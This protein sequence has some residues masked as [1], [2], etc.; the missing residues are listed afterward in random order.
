[1][2]KIRQG[3]AGERITACPVHLLD[4]LVNN[5]L[6]PG[7]SIRSMGHFPNAAGHYI[8]RPCG[9]AEYIFIYCTNGRGWYVLF[10]EKHEVRAG[11]YFILP[12]GV[13][14]SYGASDGEPW[15]IYWAHFI[16][17]KA[18]SVYESM[19]GTHTLKIEEKTRIA[20][21][22]RMFDELLNVMERRTD[23][24]S[25]LYV[26][27]GFY[28]IMSTLMFVDAFR[29]ARY[30]SAPPQNIRFLNRITHFMMENI[31]RNITVGDMAEYMGY[32]ESHFHRKF[33]KETGISPLAYY[34]KAKAEA[35]CTLL[36]DTDLNIIQ[37]SMKLGFHDPYYFSRFFKKNTGLS[38]TDFRLLQR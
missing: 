36:R 3:F 32:S 37:I 22:V 17:P 7:I 28:R 34:A 15:H 1:M 8:D 23:H 14:H 18:M 33:L 12:A 9:R 10:G 2:L 19:K 11:Q 13:P 5:P 24:D 35:A 29:E 31:D 26:C 6:N 4:S 30:P 16:G 27:I 21:R 25:M 20:D 38:P